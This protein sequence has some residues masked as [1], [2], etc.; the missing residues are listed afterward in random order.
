MTISKYNRFIRAAEAIDA[1]VTSFSCNA[2]S[3][4]QSSPLLDYYNTFA[5]EHENAFK[6]GF[7]ISDFGGFDYERDCNARQHRV[8]MLLLAAEVGKDEGFK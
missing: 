3:L 8:M 1:R 4:R 7:C 5:P 2:V 6:R